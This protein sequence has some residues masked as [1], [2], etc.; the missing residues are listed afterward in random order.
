MNVPV[1]DRYDRIAVML[2]W[3]LAAALLAQISFGWLL[4]E[5]ERNTPARASAIN[6]HKS[7][8]LILALLVLLRLL[9]RQRHKPP[10]YPA[11]MDRRALRAARAGH[12]LLYV[13]MVG[14]P[15][16]GYLAS[17][18]S[19]HGINFLNQLRLPPWG[20]DDKVTYALL[21]GT[22][23]VLA[24]VFSALVA[25]HI[26]IALY[27]ARIARDGLFSRMTFGSRP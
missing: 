1:Q 22:H 23:D 10:A 8:G 19:R 25:G 27:H 3:V 17:N 12:L 18:F 5:F 21:N 15:L 26:L 6:W 9:W 20:P 14:L 24:Y 4:G 7:S 16:S 11:G 13:C 2:H